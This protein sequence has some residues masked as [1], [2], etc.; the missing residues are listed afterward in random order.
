[1]LLFPY[2]PRNKDF[3]A[4]GERKKRKLGRSRNVLTL[5]VPQPSDVI[6]TELFSTKIQIRK[7]GVGLPGSGLYSGQLSGGH[8]PPLLLFYLFYGKSIKDPH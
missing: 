5:R 4:G 6:T 7:R 1:M 2:S 3:K 8:I